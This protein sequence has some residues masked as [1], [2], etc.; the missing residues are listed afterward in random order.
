MIVL[1]ISAVIVASMALF[2]G[3]LKLLQKH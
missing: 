2:Y 3:E 1:E